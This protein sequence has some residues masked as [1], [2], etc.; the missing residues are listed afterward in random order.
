MGSQGKS[1]P[2]IARA[3][4]QANAAALPDLER[5]FGELERGL[6]PLGAGAMLHSAQDSLADPTLAQKVAARFGI[7]LQSLPGSDH[8][9]QQSPAAIPKIIQAIEATFTKS[10]G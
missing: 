6:R 2:P 1:L 7:D 9:I 8:V 10:R 5:F 4:G 3:Q